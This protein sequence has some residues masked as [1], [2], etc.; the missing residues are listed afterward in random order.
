MKNITKFLCILIF[1]CFIICLNCTY[2]VSDNAVENDTLSVDYQSE[3]IYSDSID[4]SSDDNHVD[5][6][7]ENSSDVKI[8]DDNV[9]PSNVVKKASSTVKTTITAKDVLSITKTELL[10]KL[11]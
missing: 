8:K 1:F 6:K 11:I 9:K 3:D 10:L 7:I 5:E 4:V 2:A